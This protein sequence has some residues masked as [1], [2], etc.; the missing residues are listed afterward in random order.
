MTTPDRRASDKLTQA[1]VAAACRGDKIP[2]GDYSIAHLFT[3]EDEQSRRLATRLCSSCAVIAECGEVGN[4][5][6]FG[7][8]GGRDVTVRPGRKKQR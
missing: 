2:C 4:H 6:N 3:A 7:V 1:L 8:Y 5:S